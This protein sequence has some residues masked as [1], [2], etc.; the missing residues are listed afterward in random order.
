MAGAGLDPCR[1]PVVRY[2]HRHPHRDAVLQVR[3]PGVLSLWKGNRI[4]RRCHVPSGESPVAGLKRDSAGP[5]RGYK[6]HP[7][8]LHDHRNSLWSAV[9]QDCQAGIDAIRG[10]GALTAAP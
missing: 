8:V 2:D 9:L 5:V 1:H 6:R 4:R 10:H 7:P 3:L